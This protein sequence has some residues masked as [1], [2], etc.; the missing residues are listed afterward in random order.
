MQH[1]Q[2]S[3]KF[4][5]LLTQYHATNLSDSLV[6]VLSDFIVEKKEANKNVFIEVESSDQAIFNEQGKYLL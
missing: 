4:Y 2:E 5:E 6:S 3:S 1:Q